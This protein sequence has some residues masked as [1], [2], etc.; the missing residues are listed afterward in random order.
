[1]RCPVR[2][3]SHIHSIGHDP[4]TGTLAVRFQ[5]GGTYHHEG[6]PPEVYDDFHACVSPGSFY[7]ENIKDQYPCTKA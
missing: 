6:V 3:S 4:E 7:R 5:R 1:M 2:L